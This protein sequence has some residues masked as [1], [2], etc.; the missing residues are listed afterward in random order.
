MNCDVTIDVGSKGA[1]AIR[2]IRDGLIAEHLGAS[3]KRVSGLIDETGSL[4]QTIETL[5]GRGR[6]L[7]P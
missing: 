5:R 4:I 2:D 6:T 1:S 3:L 7:R